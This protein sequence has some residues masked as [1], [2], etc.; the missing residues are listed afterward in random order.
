VARLQGRLAAE[1]ADGT[2]RPLAE[3]DPVFEGDTLATGKHAMALVVFRDDTRITLQSETRFKVEQYR[4]RKDGSGSVLLRHLRGGL[5][6]LTGLIAKK[7]RKHFRI[8][9]PT[10]V[11]GI[12]GTGGDIVPAP[13]G[14]FYYFVW[15]GAIDLEMAGRQLPV[16]TGQAA[17]AKAGQPMVLLKAIPVPLLNNPVWR[18]DRVPVDLPELFG[19]ARS[20][21]MYLHVWNGVAVLTPRG[22]QPMD[23]AAGQSVLL[24][25]ERLQPVVL[26]ATPAFFLQIPAPR[27]DGVPVDLQQLF[28]VADRIEIKPG[29]YVNVY[30]GHV[31][32]QSGLGRVDAGGGEA[33]FAGEAE[34]VRLPALL[35]FLMND[36]APRPL[37]V[38][39][40]NPAFQ[41]LFE[42]EVLLWQ[43]EQGCQCQ[44]GFK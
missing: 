28:S 31:V 24:P 16:E 23:V 4:Y 26:P 42:E 9:T 40:D 25:A 35:G 8:H 44:I 30:S 13:D 10:A 43:L 37:D 21:N 32:L 19:L 11:V 3:G 18:P 29:V 15:H 5:R 41:Q 17:L 20:L 39:P 33:A 2:Q 6:F 14:G 36:E 22:G 34:L 1:Q 7:N 27:P 38:T 12:R